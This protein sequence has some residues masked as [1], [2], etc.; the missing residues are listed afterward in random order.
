MISFEFA[1]V[2]SLGVL[3]FGDLIVGVVND[4][5]NFLQSA[6]G[7]RVAS[8]RVVFIAAGIGLLF[9]ALFSDGII[10]VARKGIFHPGF[11]GTTEVIMVFAAVAIT[12]ILLLDLY[13]TYGLPTST[14]VSVVFE[15]LGAALVMALW[16]SG[17]D[18]DGAWDAVNSA[19]A[20]RIIT[21]ILLSIAVAF[22]A[23]LIVQ[24]FSRLFYTFDFA[25]QHKRWGFIWCGFAL[26]A[27]LFFILLK[28]GKHAVF[29]TQGVEAW[30]KGNITLLLM[31]SFVFFSTVSFVLIRMKV[32]LLT[33]II[34][35]GTASLAMAFAGNDLANFIGVSIAG[36]S[37]FFGAELEGTLVT[38]WWVLSGAGVVMMIA[39]YRSKKAN[40]VISTGVDLSSKN[41]QVLN[42]WKPGKFTKVFVALNLFVWDLLMKFVPRRV[43]DWVGG[44]WEATDHHKNGDHD[45]DLVRAGVNLMVAAAVISFATSLKL[46][47]STTYV[48]FM[49]AMGTS[50]ADGAWDR[51][52]AAHRV[53]GVMM[54]IGGWFV[55]AAGAFVAAGVVVSVLHLLRG[56]GL[57]L[58]IVSVVAIVWKLSKVHAG[59]EHKAVRSL[60]EEKRAMFEEVMA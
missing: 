32:K 42:N 8:R 11:F 13:S 48:T 31:G 44:R 24:F 51:E 45:Y 5:V 12:D 14:T 16:K 55:T 18:F 52:C 57:M 26:S 29:M 60:I 49:V 38:P 25:R 20:L 22:T 58:M 39:L 28:G 17:W 6:I 53:H 59:R 3:A 46:P 9:G 15:L 33:L 50:L 21:G 37:A 35:I 47:L 7:S 36:I 43:R 34:L 10:E 54:V 23:G 2:I 30:I 40:S 41:K 1:L 27:L 56:Y 4:A 19:S